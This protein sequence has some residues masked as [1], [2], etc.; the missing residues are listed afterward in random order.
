MAHGNTILRYGD[1]RGRRMT[2]DQALTELRRNEF[3]PDFSVPT[4]VTRHR[5]GTETVIRHW[6]RDH[7]PGYHNR[8]VTRATFSI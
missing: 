7:L 6:I 8:A 2:E 4:M 1:R 5:N 3:R